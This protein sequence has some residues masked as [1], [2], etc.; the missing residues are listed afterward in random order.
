MGT[1]TTDEGTRPSYNLSVPDIFPF[2]GYGLVLLLRYRFDAKSISA[3][4][5]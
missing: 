5:V 4:N 2:T 3:A 1:L